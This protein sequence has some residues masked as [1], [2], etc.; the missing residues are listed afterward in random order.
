MPLPA[1]PL[2]VRARERV[3]EGGGALPPFR[4]PSVPEKELEREVEPE[5][6]EAP[7]K[8]G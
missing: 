2:P 3:G 4:C 5:E 7:R 1:L 6:G 8:V